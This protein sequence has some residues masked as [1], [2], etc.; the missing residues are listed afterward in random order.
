MR[1]VLSMLAVIVGALVA[2]AF[3]QAAVPVHF[4]FVNGRGETITIEPV[5]PGCSI[6]KTSLETGKT[7]GVDCPTEV[8]KQTGIQVRVPGGAGVICYPFVAVMDQYRIE[9]S[10]IGAPSCSMST[11]GHASYKLVFAR[12]AFLTIEL[13]NA[14]AGDILAHM[15][16]YNCKPNGEARVAP[17][18]THTY[19]CFREDMA[20]GQGI[21]IQA[22]VPNDTRDL[23]CQGWWHENKTHVFHG[24]CSIDHAGG[25]RYI[26]TIR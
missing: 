1:A 19:N 22:R 23:I 7:L 2:P 16:N 13:K 21:T 26:L 6:G 9:A 15:S 24:N 17:G 5:Y 12:A 3:A 4:E 25:D 8:G 10:Q 11:V 20:A 18:G 14:R